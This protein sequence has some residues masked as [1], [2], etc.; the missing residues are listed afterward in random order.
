MKLLAQRVNVHVSVL[1][2]ALC[3]PTSNGGDTGVSGLTRRFLTS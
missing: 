1:G 2:T 3:T